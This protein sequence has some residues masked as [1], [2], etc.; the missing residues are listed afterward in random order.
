M[1]S[2][3]SNNFFR[4]SFLFKYVLNAGL[5]DPDLKLDQGVCKK[6]LFI[7]RLCAGMALLI[8]VFAAAIVVT[9]D[10]DG[11]ARTVLQFI[12][13]PSIV[14]LFNNLKWYLRSR[15]FFVLFTSVFVLVSYYLKNSQLIAENPLLG[16]RDPTSVKELYF[17]LIVGAILIFD[18]QKE[19]IWFILSVAIMCC[20]FFF[21]EE[22]QE[23]LGLPMSDKPY[24]VLDKSRVRISLAFDLAIVLIGIL[25]IVSLN[26][27]FEQELT[28]QRDQML[29]QSELTNDQ[30]IELEHQQHQL[31][32]AIEATNRV[33][34][35]AVENGNFRARVDISDREGDWKNLGESI[36]HLLDSV[37]KPFEEINRVVSHLSEGNLTERF[38]LHVKGDVAQLA[39]N[40]NEAVDNLQTLIIDIQ[41]QTQVTARFSQ[42]LLDRNEGFVQ[43]LE[44]IK[45]SIGEIRKA[46]QQQV[47]EINRSSA[48]IA[49]LGGASGT[50]DEQAN[51]ID[52]TA[53]EGVSKSSEGV[54]VLVNAEQEMAQINDFFVK[55]VEA[56]DVLVSQADQITGSLDLIHTITSQTNL[57]ALNA[58]IEAAQAGEAGRGFAVVASEMRVL[59]EKAKDSA[60]QISSLTVKVKES[61]NETIE[62]L[63][64]MGERIKSGQLAFQNVTTVF[65]TITQTY[66][67]TQE[68]SDKIVVSTASQ[69]S[70]MEEIM[71]AIKNIVVVSEETASGTSQV[72]VSSAQFS[73]EMDHF[74]QDLKKITTISAELLERVKFFRLREEES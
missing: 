50:I 34:N 32:Q 2:T 22:I 67:K 46:T 44:D 17:P 62:Y 23:L 1:D 54:S 8:I 27:K 15:I 52:Q 56:I 74:S 59:A 24:E 20:F 41:K 28:A 30:N 57:L 51:R 13:I 33:I 5:N 63:N 66:Q 21:F 48:L 73:K 10:A 65:D 9:G 16:A 53:V 64:R 11:I 70:D 25:S 3:R 42:G 49:N 14:I 68:L 35:E 39:N 31:Q 58:S 72:A 19:R 55:S 37:L 40:L 7:N 12:L 26:S 43:G 18:Y 6:V 47:E 4:R 45:L 38:E 61:S 29:D 36:N 71:G 60:K 69:S